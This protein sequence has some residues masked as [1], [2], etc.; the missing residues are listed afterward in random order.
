M[1]DSVDF[2]DLGRV[3]F[4]VKGNEHFPASRASV[5]GKR[6]WVTSLAI[7]GRRI[8]GTVLLR[9]NARDCSMDRVAGAGGVG[10]LGS[11]D[12]TKSV[13][14]NGRWWRGYLVVFR[15]ESLEDGVD[16][17]L[18]DGLGIDVEGWQV[19]SLGD[20]HDGKR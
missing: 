15:H 8:A 6:F 7:V 10:T 11:D 18:V 17:L 20:R 13:V 12:P 3:V 16:V 2:R 5:L 1:Q 4:L 14:G 19:A 9:G